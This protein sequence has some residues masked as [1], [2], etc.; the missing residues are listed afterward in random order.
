MSDGRSYVALAAAHQDAPI[1]S[2]SDSRHQAASL[3]EI[4]EKQLDKS[5]FYPKH[6]HSITL[7]AN[8]VIL[9]DPNE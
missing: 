8:S 1:N 3:F 4:H 9:L 2:D 7:Q 6:I 5:F